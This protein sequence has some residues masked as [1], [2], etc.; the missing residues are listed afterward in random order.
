M[1][2]TELA[3]LAAELD[4]VDVDVYTSVNKDPTAPIIGEGPI[5]CRVAVFGRD[6]GRTEVEVGAPFVGAGGRLVRNALSEHL[7]GRGLAKGDLG[8]DVGARLFWANTVPYKPVGNKAWSIRVQRQ[9]RPVMADL[10]LTRWRGSDVITLGREAFFWFGL[11]DAATNAA[12]TS[13]WERDDRFSASLEVPLVGRDGR[14]R[15]VRLHPL[16]HPSPLNATWYRKVPELLK[17]RL[18]VLGW[19]DATWRLG[20]AADGDV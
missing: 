15:G 11:E 16:P 5:D 19:T 1:W 2:E 20:G 13:F 6:P 9:F 7:F 12:L 4:G 18:S 14:R 3:A 17:A 8:L 10:L